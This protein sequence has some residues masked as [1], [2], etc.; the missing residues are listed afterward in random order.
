MAM[1]ESAATASG[2]AAQELHVIRSQIRHDLAAKDGG[3]RVALARRLS[4]H[5]AK[6][7]AESSERKAA[8]E[9]ARQLAH[10]AV[11]IV[12]QQLAEAVK[13]YSFLPRDIALKI[14]HDVDSVACPFLEATEVFAEED[15]QQLILTVTCRARVS[16]A[17]RETV[18]ERLAESLAQIGEAEV[19]DALVANARARIPGPAYTTMMERFA[20]RTTLMERMAARRELPADIVIALVS[21]VSKAARE[22]LAR[23]YDLEDF[24]NPVAVE[25]HVSSLLRIVGSTP[26]GELRTYAENLNRRSEL[27]PGFLLRALDDGHIDFVEAA[28]AVQARITVDDARKLIRFGGET[29]VA[30]LCEKAGI[31]PPLQRDFQARFAKAQPKNVA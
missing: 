9:L 8:E 29:A 20:D 27:S 14:A 10:D 4:D 21:K 18:S 13:S 3:D 31:A 6:T 28:F 12:R 17:S 23:D 16:I 1:L 7:G 15:W 11:E 2:P 22:K 30:K 5:L 24:T 25:A 26:V 19:G